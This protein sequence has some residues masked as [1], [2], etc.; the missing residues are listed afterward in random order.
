MI[1]MKK[2]W[3]N[4]VGR[5]LGAG[6]MA[7]ALLG[8][9]ARVSRAQTPASEVHAKGDISG[10]WQGTLQAQKALRTVVRISK[11]EKGWTAKF[12]SIDQ[13]P[14]PISVTSTTTD[15]STVKL[16]I[17]MIG[18]SYTGTLSADGNT[19]TG[20]WTQ[21]PN[22]LPLTLVRATKETAWE[23][24]APPPP[25]KRMDPN[26]DPSFDVATIKPSD[27]NMQ[28]KGFNSN[29]R[30]FRTRGTTLDD[31]IE[32]AYDLHAKQIVNAP[33]WMDKDKF[34]LECTTDTEGDPSYEQTKSMLRKLIV[35]R[36]KLTFHNEKKVMSVYVLTVE[37]GGP[38]NLT[39]SESTAPGFSIP[40]QPTPG[41]IRLI[42]RNGTMTN[43]AVFGLQGAVL[44][45]PVLDQTGLPDRFDFSV[46]WMPDESQFG[47]H[48][49]APES[50]NPL[51]GLY[52]AMHEQL[53]LKL[54]A[55][56][57]PADVMAIDKVEKPSAN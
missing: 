45:R 49:K 35:D 47:G 42:V 29:G 16:V 8:L 55:T 48:M 56:K 13:N 50:E 28:G 39:K 41:G 21:G 17:D 18:G 11:A 9:P 10:D 22:P 33:D 24:P 31:L 19:L 5:L 51:P 34:D 54:E 23:I 1:V 53:G 26:A 30:S 27:P 25:R 15:G 38:K 44:D 43:F 3:R 2:I 4:R 57:A 6:L 12:Y 40:I 32:F 46:K 20:T 37:P 7:I 14:T 36:F 52:T